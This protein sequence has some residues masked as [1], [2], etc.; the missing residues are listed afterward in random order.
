MNDLV[1]LF[2]KGLRDSLS[3]RQSLKDVLSSQELTKRTI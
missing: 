2:L 3:L 1:S